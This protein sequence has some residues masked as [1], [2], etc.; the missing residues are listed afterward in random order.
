MSGELKKAVVS[1]DS[2]TLTTAA[3]TKALCLT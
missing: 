2:F 1:G 3:E